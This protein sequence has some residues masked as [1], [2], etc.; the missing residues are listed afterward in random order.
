[1][2]FPDITKGKV[3]LQTPL[4]TEYEIS[5]VGRVWV[6]RTDYEEATHKGGGVVCDLV[7]NPDDSA[8]K[9]LWAIVRLQDSTPDLT[10]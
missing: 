3:L 2:N 4:G 9:A 8:P 6:S 7:S 10:T 5:E 1:M